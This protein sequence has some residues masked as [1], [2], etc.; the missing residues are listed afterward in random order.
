MDDLR[1]RKMD[2]PEGQANMA[3]A[4]SLRPGDVIRY[5]YEHSSPLLMFVGN[6][7][8]PSGKSNYIRKKFVRLC[9]RGGANPT[10]VYALHGDWELLFHIDDWAR[11]A[12]E[13]HAND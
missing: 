6:T 9:F 5:V 11:I 3:R 13:V 4:A 1:L 10:V 2:T 7:L 12:K 8:P